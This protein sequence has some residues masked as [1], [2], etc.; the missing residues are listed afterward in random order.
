MGTL[1]KFNVDDRVNLSEIAGHFLAV[2]ERIYT[3][4]YGALLSRSSLFLA[5]ARYSRDAR[6][7]TLAFFFRPGDDIY[8]GRRFLLKNRNAT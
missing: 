6:Y 7:Y 4:H 8:T 2:R 3:F 1:G 5:C